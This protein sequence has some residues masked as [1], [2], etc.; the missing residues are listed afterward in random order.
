[1]PGPLVRPAR[2]KE[3]ALLSALAIASKAYWGYSAEQMAVFEGELT[4]TRADLAGEA[5]V[6]DPGR[7]P[8]GF[9]ILVSAGPATL[10]IQHLFVAVDRLRE[11]LG[12][13][14]LHHARQRAAACGA[15]RLV[16][17]SDPNAEGFY[18]AHGGRVLDRIASSIPG[19]TIPWM[20]LPRPAPQGD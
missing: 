4:L 19:R 16:V 1:L 5:H 20:E 13:T 6:L 18:A 14:L 9:Y 7:G 2:A 10:E 11:G 15:E 3:A 12:S 17:Q 8:V